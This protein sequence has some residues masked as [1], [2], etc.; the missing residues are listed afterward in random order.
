MH[1][2]DNV[3]HIKFIGKMMLFQKYF[4]Y[5]IRIFLFWLGRAL[6]SKQLKFYFLIAIKNHLLQKEFLKV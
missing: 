2:I 3:K 4:V 1:Q 5:K 6:H